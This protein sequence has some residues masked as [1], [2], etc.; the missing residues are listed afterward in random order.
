MVK[1]LQARWLGTVG[2]QRAFVR[3]ITS[4][5]EHPCVVPVHSV[6]T[7]ADGRPFYS[8]RYVDGQTMHQAIETLHKIKQL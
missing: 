3:E 2:A 6:G 7:T 4:P 8:M 1:Q 5:F